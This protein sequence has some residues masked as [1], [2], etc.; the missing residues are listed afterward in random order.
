MRQRSKKNTSADST[1]KRWNSDQIERKV[2]KA[3]GLKLEQMRDE[4]GYE[5]CQHDIGDGKICGKNRNCGESLDCSH[6]ISVERC[7][8]DP[9]VNLELA[10]DVDNITIRCRFHH[11][12]WDKS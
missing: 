5:F 8:N 1:G 12:E 2:S 10:W 6:D 7:K 9:T 3:K 11:R 4:Y